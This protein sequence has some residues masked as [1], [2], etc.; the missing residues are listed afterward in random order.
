MTA[1]EAVPDHLR[2]NRTDGRQ[3]RCN[4]PVLKDKKLCQIHHL[5]GRHRQ[6][7][8]KVPES[9]K[10]QRKAKRSL[11]SNGGIRKIRAKNPERLLKLAEKPM[12][13]IEK[14][15]ALDEAVK[16]MKLKRGDLQLELIRLVLKRQV[17]DKR[18]NRHCD[19]S[20]NE[21]RQ[22]EDV[23]EEEF[24]KDLPNGLMSISSFSNNPNE[25]NA[26]PSCDVKIGAHFTQTRC[27]RSKNIQPMPI[28][29]MQVLPWKENVLS[30][31]RGMR[32]RCHYCK[33]GGVKKLVK[34][35]SCRKEFFCIDCIK[36][37]YFESEEELRMTCPVCRGSCGC[38]TCSTN[39]DNENCSEDLLRE[40]N[41][42]DKVLWFH[43][44]ICK[45]L[46]IWKQ[47]NQEEHIELEIEANLKGQKPCDVSIQLAQS[48]CDKQHFCNN[49]KS[50]ILNIHR[51][52]QSCSYSL[53]LNCGWDDFQNQLPDDIKVLLCKFLNERKTCNLFSESKY[54]S[55]SMKSCRTYFDSSTSPPS[56]EAPDS[57][58]GIISCPPTELGGC[59]DGVLGLKIIFPLNWIKDLERRAEEIVGSYEVPEKIDMYSHCLL[60]SG[61][62]EI[63]QQAA[64]RDDSN[65]NFLYFPTAS[66]VHVDNSE[67]FQKHWGKGHPV[68]VRNVLQDVSDLNWDPIV[69]F[70]A[71]LEN[72]CSKSENDE[73]VNEANNCAD[74]FE[75]EIGVRQLFLGSLR[76]QTNTNICDEKLKLKGWLSSI[77]F[78][79]QFP[80]H[81]AQVINALPLPEYMDPKSGLLNIAAKLPQDIQ[82]PDL[83]P[84]VYISYSSGRELTQEESVRKLSYA[85]S[86]VVNILV[87]VTNIPVS[88][89]ELD[90]IRKLMRKA[91]DQKESTEVAPHVK[92][93]ACQVKRNPPMGKESD[94]CLKDR[95]FSLNR[96]SISGFDTDSEETNFKTIE[97]WRTSENKVVCGD[98][99]ECLGKEKNKDVDE[100]CGAQWDV[101][102]RQDVSK[103]IEY[104]RRH[105]KEFS[106]QNGC[107]QKLV[108]H[109]IFDQNYFLDAT[110]KKRLKEE[111]NIEPWS[112]GQH[113]GEAV[114]IPAGCPYQVQNLK[115]CV[116]VVLDFV[117]PE[118]LT[119]TIQLTE[120]V[121][122]LPDDHKAKAYKPEVKFRIICHL[123]SPWAVKC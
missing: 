21:Q 91:Q 22:D 28:G 44:L 51:S 53:C 40:K 77:L 62:N 43:Y 102:R 78:Q 65:D 64:A 120:D 31:R 54:L 9:L 17:D 12:K 119:E 67:H 13:F 49:C 15:E 82:K 105:S 47:I 81:Y 85:M 79:K 87:H 41:K 95:G 10:I 122:L 73:E 93:Q 88:T 107:S 74:W 45:L 116:S 23:D 109:P 11:L 94:S 83:G 25:Y 38:K 46:P 56:K 7:K 80:A 42:F 97:Q 98:Q 26:G 19:Y 1:K 35:S 92:N 76:G 114:V 71:Y 90:I 72:S 30:L 20:D 4:R 68:V 18:R 118:N 58:I 5:Q 66:E 24:V 32:K 48:S 29:A 57:S 63:K 52:C 108:L 84:S 115:S 113:V 100:S 6:F 106:P 3:W 16:K 8:Q 33:K 99:A 14:S 61:M 39:Q 117:S 103:L 96:E 37:R 27:F 55:T 69:M 60:C 36:E 104:L 59:G 2:C 112:F 86:D 110:H 101:F 111:F 121:R 70:C 89:K 50:S 75:V 34:C 123:R